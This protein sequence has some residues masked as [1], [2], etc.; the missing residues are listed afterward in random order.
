MLDAVNVI[1]LYARQRREWS[2]IAHSNQNASHVQ[3]RIFRPNIEHFDVE[4][5][6][7]SLS[8]HLR[9]DR[10]I[11]IDKRMSFLGQAAAFSI[12][13]GLFDGGSAG[14]Q[15]S[16][17]YCPQL[18]LVKGCFPCSGSPRQEDEYGFLCGWI[19]A[20]GNFFD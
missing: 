1:M 16:R 5:G 14:F 15:K 12:R 7:L 3:I 19:L 10:R 9:I 4:T 6:F 2:T 13:F 20:S 8:N 17:E 18:A 11:L